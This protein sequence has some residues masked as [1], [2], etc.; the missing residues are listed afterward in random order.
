MST[1]KDQS[2]PPITEAFIAY[3]GHSG[4]VAPLFAVGVEGRQQW[5]R[6]IMPAVRRVIVELAGKRKPDPH[7]SFRGQSLA[8]LFS[9]E[10]ITNVEGQQLATFERMA[11]SGKYWVI[12][13]H[14]DHTTTLTRPTVSSD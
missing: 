10:A 8:P 5:H 1:T 3:G 2:V 7:R 12:L 4:T 14:A 13:I 9:V 6:D 11:A